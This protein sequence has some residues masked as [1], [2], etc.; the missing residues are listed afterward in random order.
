LPFA[1][2]KAEAADPDVYAP[3][4]FVGIG[5]SGQIEIIA[6]AHAKDRPFRSP[7][8]SQQRFARDP[9]TPKA[10][11]PYFLRPTASGGAQRA[12]ASL[13]MSTVG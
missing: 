9:S 7:S 11:G 6:I 12:R 2:G 10:S 1:N 4:A 5:G 8:S 3:N 13:C